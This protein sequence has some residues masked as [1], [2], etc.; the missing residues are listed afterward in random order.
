MPQLQ[1]GETV[2][3]PMSVLVLLTL[4]AACSLFLAPNSSTNGKYTNREESCGARWLQ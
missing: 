3:W 2:T 4:E 1:H